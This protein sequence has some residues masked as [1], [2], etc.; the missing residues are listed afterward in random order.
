M[1]LLSVLQFLVLGTIGILIAEYL[2]G[3]KNDFG[4][5]HAISVMF[6]LYGGYFLS[7]EIENFTGE[8][9]WGYAVFGIAG[10][11]LVLILVSRVMFL[12]SM[13]SR[14]S[15]RLKKVMTKSSEK[16]SAHK[17]SKRN[18][19]TEGSSNK[20]SNKKTS[21]N[22]PLVA[23][24]QELKPEQNQPSNTE[25]IERAIP[26]RKDPRIVTE[27]RKSAKARR[28][29]TYK[30]SD[31]SKSHKSLTD[32]DLV[33]T[34]YPTISSPHQ[35]APWSYPA[36]KCPKPN[37]IVRSHRIGASKRRGFK[38][39]SF[40]KTIRHFFGTEFDVLGRT[41]LNVG[42]ITRPFEPDIAMISSS[43]GYNVRIDIEID[44]PYSGISRKPT[45]CIGD[46]DGRD[47]FFSDRG[48]MVVRFTEFQ[49]H[50]EELACVGFLLHILRQIQ[51][52]YK[53]D[54][55]LQPKPEESHQW[56]TLQAQK[57]ARENWRESYLGH[58][59][60]HVEEQLETGDRDLNEREE[61][62]EA[63]V[64]KTRLFEVEHPSVEG[65]NS[66]YFHDR[67]SRINFYPE[68]HAY[69]IDGVPVT[70]VSTLVA[71]FFPEF[72]SLYWAEKKA[73]KQNQSTKQLLEDW[74]RNGENASRL[75]TRLHHDIEQ[76]YLNGKRANSQEFEHFLT[77]HAAHKHLKPFRSEW[78]IFDESIGIAGTVDLVVHNG[79]D[80]DLFDWKRS[81]KLI[82][83]INGKA[84]IEKTNPSQQGLGPLNH[85]DDTSYNRYCLQQNI[86]SRILE[87]RYDLRIRN[88]FLVVIHPNYSTF[89]K[90]RVNRMENEVAYI[91]DN[92]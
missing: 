9:G 82:Q 64:K 59:F 14:K 74:R 38:E 45:H 26:P 28:S 80:Y 22:I 15:T 87:E 72:D 4:L 62:E 40:E 31:R 36:W 24:N 8:T 35:T 20:S 1:I 25:K 92:I 5:V 69:E 18:L 70:S 55:N 76:Y 10:V 49:V 65:F 53:G 46:D 34:N 56:T 29:Q 63:K 17:P 90:I 30:S 61:R 84:F 21:S 77:F 67:D 37:T 91:L 13:R 52:Q 81:K 6:T 7:L 54:L 12:E 32:S 19:S 85:L 11:V 57:W 60:R 48:W 39:E 58:Q 43:F 47:T 86:Y 71:R 16:V 66:K 41:R 44:E 79:R 33:L 75:G 88:M 23:S 83:E 68:P 27:S 78:R 42:G 51:P 89:H 73:A 50:T 3:N 2:T